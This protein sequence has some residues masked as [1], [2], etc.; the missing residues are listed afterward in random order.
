MTMILALGGI[1]S[2]AQL[3]TPGSFPGI[4]VDR[5]DCEMNCSRDEAM[6]ILRKWCHD[7][8]NL[9]LAFQ[10]SAAPRSFA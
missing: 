7:R 9:R 6:L 3:V 8:V 4:V 5:R 10:V 1:G 2:V